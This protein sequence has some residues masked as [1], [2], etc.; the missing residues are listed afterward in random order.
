MENM[1]ENDLAVGFMF[2]NLAEK[3]P[4]M[5]AISLD[6]PIYVDVSVIRKKDVYVSEGVKKIE[7]YLKENIRF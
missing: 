4:F 6:P 2:K 7:R 5:A 1:I 3:N